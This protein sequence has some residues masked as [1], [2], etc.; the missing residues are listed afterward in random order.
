LVNKEKLLEFI[1]DL[2]ESTTER[3]DLYFIGQTTRL[4]EGWINWI[5][6]IEFAADVYEQDRSIL[7]SRI[8]HFRNR[9]QIRIVE[10]SPAEVIPLPEDYP[11]RRRQ[12]STADFPH[13]GELRIY[14]FDPYSVAFRYIARGDE[15]DYHM[16]LDFLKHGWITEEKMNQ[17]LE[18]LLPRFSFQTIQQDPAEFRRRYKGLLQMWHSQEGRSRKVN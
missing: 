2:A 7:E 14:H 5:E 8:Q 1:T 3:G 12:V 13:S 18:E 9:H 6:E 16:V 17:I 11:S 4:M 15:Q 10:E